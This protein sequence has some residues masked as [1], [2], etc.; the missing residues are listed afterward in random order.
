MSIPAQNIRTET[1]AI[2]PYLTKAFMEAQQRAFA[3]Y[4]RGYEPYAGDR[5]AGFNDLLQQAERL[6]NQTGKYSPYFD[7]AQQNINRGS[8]SF[9]NNYQPYLNPRQDALLRGIE[10]EGN[11]ALKEKVLPGIDARYIALGQHGSSRHAQMAKRATRDLQRQIANSQEEALS[12]GYGQALKGFADDRARE[13]ESGRLLSE[14][15]IGRQ[16]YNTAQIRALQEAGLLRHERDQTE[17]DFAYE[18]W[19]ERQRHPSE[20]LANYFSILAGTPFVPSRYRRSEIRQ[21]RPSWHHQDWRD[22][23]AGLLTDLILNRR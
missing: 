21:L 6:S 18:M 15:G 11:R 4:Q 10:E 14:L 13:L 9:L 22:L 5:L 17:R 1:G 2:P 19:K 20:S 23:G 16:S 3:N 8:E 12:R 7:R